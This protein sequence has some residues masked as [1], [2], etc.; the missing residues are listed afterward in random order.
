MGKQNNDSEYQII[1][2]NIQCIDGNHSEFIVFVYEEKYTMN[3]THFTNIY[4]STFNNKYTVSNDKNAINDIKGHI[5]YPLVYQS[6]VSNTVMITYLCNDVSTRNKI[7]WIDSDDKLRQTNHESILVSVNNTETIKYYNIIPLSIGGYI[8]MYSVTEQIFITF[9]GENGRKMSE[10]TSDIFIEYETNNTANNGQIIELHSENVLFDTPRSETYIFITF[11]VFEES[12]DKLIG[13]V[14]Y[15]NINSDN[16]IIYT[17]IGDRIELNSFANNGDISARIEP[18]FVCI[19]YDKKSD[20]I[21]IGWVSNYHSFEYKPFYFKMGDTDT[22][23]N[24]I[25]ST[26]WLIETSEMA[27]ES[28]NGNDMNGINVS[29]QNNLINESVLRVIRATLNIF[30]MRECL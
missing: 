28:T 25:F 18:N 17:R 21:V 2:Q 29:T 23:T 22:D 10:D 14:Y 16:D 11:A 24:G 3:G 27:M 12:R 9:I 26:E 6:L 19:N 13:L 4:K 7:Y 8:L 1:H 15:I 20:M 30:F 5:S